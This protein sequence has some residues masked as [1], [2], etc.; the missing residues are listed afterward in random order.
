MARPSWTQARAVSV[1][2]PA[3]QLVPDQELNHGALRLNC[4]ERPKPYGSDPLLMSLSARLAVTSL[5]ARSG[6]MRCRRGARARKN[7]QNRWNQQNRNQD[8]ASARH[9]HGHEMPRSERPAGVQ[10][11]AVLGAPRDAAARTRPRQAPRDERP[12]PPREPPREPPRP[13]SGGERSRPGLRGPQ[14]QAGARVRGARQATRRAL[15][16][17]Q[18]GEQVGRCGRSQ[19]IHAPRPRALEMSD[20]RGVSSVD[21]GDGRAGLPARPVRPMRWM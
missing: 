17:V 10:P 9:G 12:R 13:P 6:R 7:R 2:K 15:G 21:E 18:V 16:N 3:L 5:A 20:Q 19:R 14:R 4:G 11:V 1:R 8:A